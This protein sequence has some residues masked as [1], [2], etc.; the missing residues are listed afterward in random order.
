MKFRIRV[1]RDGYKSRYSKV[2]DSEG[3]VAEAVNTLRDSGRLVREGD[4]PTYFGTA[5]IADAI[6]EVETVEEPAAAET[7]ESAE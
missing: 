7:S 5:Y 6:V 1:L 4:I 2:Y 3:Q